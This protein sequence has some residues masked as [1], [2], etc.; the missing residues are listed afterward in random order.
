MPT[1]GHHILA[2]DQGTTSS[3][4]ILFERT[5]KPLKTA[6]AEHRQFYPQDGWVEHDAEEIWQATLKVTREALAGGNVADV[7]AI[8]ITN[9][10]ETTVLWDRKTGRPLHH[11]IVWQ[12]MRVADDVATMARERSNDFFRRRTGL[13][14]STYFSSLKLRWLLDNMPDARRQ[15]ESGKV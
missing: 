15:A 9:Q 8:G 13:P 11:A 4:A 7:A 10:R 3:R 2:I 14:L 6:Q 5:G 12:D 1:T